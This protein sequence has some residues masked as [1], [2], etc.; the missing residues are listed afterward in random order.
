MANEERISGECSFCG[1]PVTLVRNSVA[2]T[3]RRDGNRYIYTDRQDSGWC[4]FRCRECSSLIDENWRPLQ[5]TIA[6]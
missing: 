6:T 1:E 5:I 3:C 4:I 2:R